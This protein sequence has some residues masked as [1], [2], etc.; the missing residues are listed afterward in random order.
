MEENCQNIIT[1]NPNVCHDKPTIRSMRYTVK[2]VLDLVSAGMTNEEIIKDY[3]SVTKEDIAACV[4]Y[5]SIN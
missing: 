2:L 3:P 5:S 4:K 1:N